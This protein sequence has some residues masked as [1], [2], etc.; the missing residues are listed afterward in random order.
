MQPMGASQRHNNN[1]N[2]NTQSNNSQRVYAE[3]SERL[4]E[5]Q[6]DA[7]A[8]QLNEKVN[9]LKQLSIEIGEEVKSQNKMLDNM[10]SAKKH[11]NCSFIWYRERTLSGRASRQN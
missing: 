9:L 1:N 11:I 4:F 7:M 10:V 8:A 5:E 3:Q 2:N 6:N